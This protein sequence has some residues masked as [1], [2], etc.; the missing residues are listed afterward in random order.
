MEHAEQE[1][2]RLNP[3]FFYFDIGVKRALDRTLN[4]GIQEGTYGYG[5]AFEHFIILEIVRLSSY[6]N[7]DW[8]FSYLLTKDNA[9]I[10]LIIDR[11]GLPEVLIEIKSAAITR[12][13]DVAILNRFVTDFESCEAYCISRDIHEKKINSVRCIHWEKMFSV[14]GLDGG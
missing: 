2:Q 7:N 13:R 12:E 6:L 3:K 4:L 10:D 5:R 8:Q 11:P 1:R 9:E 14:L